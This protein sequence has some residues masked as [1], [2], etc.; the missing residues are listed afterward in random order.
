MVNKTERKERNKESLR[1]DILDAA[2][3]VFVSQ[4]YE[5]ASMRKIAERIG[6]SPTTIYLYF[7]DK[8]DLLECLCN[9][10]FSQLM[11]RLRLIESE[12]TDPVDALRRGMRE[13]VEFG[14]AHPSQYQVTFMTRLGPQDTY[15]FEGSVGQQAFAHL[16][17]S[18]ESCIAHGAFRA[19]DV[20][21]ISQSLWMAIHGVTSLL[22]CDPHFPWKDRSQILDQ[23]ID[24]LLSGLKASN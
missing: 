24:T 7:K 18:V 2:R 20:E 10:T 22:I 4:G 1:R 5:N 12:A 14:L 21:L 19:G 15:V 16:C 8:S 11:T 6:Y 13:Y 3:E 17:H 9:E 23:T